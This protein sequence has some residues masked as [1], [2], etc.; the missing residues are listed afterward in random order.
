MKASPILGERIRLY[1]IQHS[2]TREEL[3]L[4]IGVE[5]LHINNV[6]SGKKGISSEKLKS[7]CQ[8]FRISLPEILSEV[9]TDK[10]DEPD[11]F[12]LRQR[13]LAEI[14]RTVEGLDTA[15]LGTVRAMVCALS[16]E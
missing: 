14:A 8:C 3:A 12:E 5:A 6:E 9:E 2:M 4:E 15:R 13:W 10:K 11:D 16:S 1:R 7:I